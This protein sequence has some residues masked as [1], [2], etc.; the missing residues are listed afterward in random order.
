MYE[1][2]KLIMNLS[3]GIN[4]PSFFIYYI[5]FISIIGIIITLYDKWA[6]KSRPEKRVRES[7]LFTLSFLGGSLAILVT[8]LLIRH[9]T[10]HLQFMLGIPVIIILQVIGLYFLIKFNL[11]SF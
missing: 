1:G 3:D 6:S 9:K 5:V 4:L 2:E 8:M 11:I 7:T 10:K